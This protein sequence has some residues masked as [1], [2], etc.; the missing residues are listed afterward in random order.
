[1]ASDGSGNIY[2]ANYGGA[3][4]AGDL[5]LIASGSANGTPAIQ[6]ASAVSVGPTSTLAIDGYS[7]LWLSSYA[8]TATT[9][10]ICSARPCTATVTT[11]GGQSAPQA[12]AVDHANDIWIGNG[13]STPGISELASTST[14]TIIGAP[15]SP[16]TGGGLSNPTRTVFGGL[17]SMWI[18]NYT[19]TGGTVS[20]LT[21]TGS[22]V[23]PSVGFTHTFS[24]ATGIAI[25][26]SGNVWVGNAGTAAP[27]SF[28]TEIVGASGPT[29]TPYSS[30]LPTT[31]GGVN[32]IGNRP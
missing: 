19:A 16:F 32:T 27:T 28:I 31:P 25:D 23:S 17:G 8:K 11:A 6:L 29:I 20:E 22:P 18:T 5:E 4:G 24:G 7:D 26:A 21:P 3:A 10:F 1:M 30:N 14:S 2:V 12:I 15:G 9:Q 13:G